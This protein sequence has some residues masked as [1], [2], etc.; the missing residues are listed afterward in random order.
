MKINQMFPSQY[1]SA[2]DLDGKHV[3][4]EIGGIRTETVHREKGEEKVFVL[5]FKGA[6]KGIIL[7]RRLA[8]EIAA[9][10][11]SDDTDHWPG[12]RL[13]IYPTQTRAFGKTFD[14]FGAKAAA[15]VAAPVLS[16]AANAQTKTAQPA[17][18]ETDNEPEDS[19]PE[20]DLPGD[21][22]YDEDEIPY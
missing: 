4:L 5:Y 18:V 11:G 19:Q 12:K 3:T 6:T 20:D 9:A 2:A 21:L 16:Q 17:P 22:S 8:L 10:V 13:V 1:A 7:S 14:V 15:P